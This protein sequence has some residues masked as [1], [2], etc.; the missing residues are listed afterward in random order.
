MT[1]RLA[2]FHLF[3]SGELIAVAWLCP[4]VVLVEQVLVA[5]EGVAGEREKRYFF[6]KVD[7]L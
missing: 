3:D 6:C 2:E 4:L 5:V 7:L 1:Y